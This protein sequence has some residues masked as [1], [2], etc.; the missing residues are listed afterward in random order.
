MT[1]IMYNE[2]LVT[3][4]Y[5]VIAAVGTTYSLDLET[6][7]EVP[8]AL[9]ELTANAEQY[10]QKPHY[11]LEV[12]NQVA[13]KFCVFC[14]A[15][16]IRDNLTQEHLLTL[17]ENS[18]CSIQLPAYGK[19]FASFH[20][21]IWIILEENKQKT[22]LKQAKV[23][24]MSR[25][26]TYSTDIDVV[27]VLTGK[28][29]RR[30]AKRASQVKHQPLIDFLH[31][32]EGNANR[33]A[34][35]KY[36]I[37]TL[38]EALKNVETFDIDGPWFDE[39]DYR[40]LPM[41]INGY[42]GKEIQK[43]MLEKATDTL[44][45][46]PFVD[47]ET[48]T[49]LANV[50]GKHALITQPQSC[51]K[52]V[53][54]LFGEDIYSTKLALT[55]PEDGN[56]IV[57]V[58]EK[59]YF[60]S[61]PSGHYLYLGSTNASQNGFNRNV[62]FMLRLHFR[63]NMASFNRLLPMFVNNDKNC[64][65]ERVTIAYPHDPDAIDEQRKLQLALR[66]AIAAIQKATIEATDNGMYTI[67]VHCKELKSNYKYAI[68]PIY[69][70]TKKQKLSQL[71]NF[72]NISLINL[73]EFYV[74]ECEEKK[75]VIKIKTFGMPSGRAQAIEN[76]ILNTQDKI[77]DY[78]AYMLS[79]DPDGYLEQM[80]LHDQEKKQKSIGGGLAFQG[81]TLYEDLLRMA[82][83]NPERIKRA[84]D[85]LSHCNESTMVDGL[86]K[87]LKDIQGVLPKIKRI[88]EEN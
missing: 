55:A 86:S 21:K 18:V 39:E 88:K 69:E 20:P 29:M 36:L 19:S 84:I 38:S 73:S 48:V 30:A 42:S 63:R 82:Y 76:N 10:V 77:I 51:S 60:I 31:W 11:L 62:E 61:N 14:N 40:F 3:P 50:R 15:G 37:T 59:I 52:E 87:L 26:L 85:T 74:I 35:V 43:E 57:N 54:Q 79:T 25:N 58:H 8:I 5:R 4:G 32:L 68:Y 24:I 64:P 23:M 44:T 13:S 49:A 81:L 1:N 34:N 65:F 41:G 67:T 46:S 2:A 27:C 71:T 12:I 53:I 47:L 9:G 22:D 17:L 75:S 45:I 28:V 6:L 72:E 83:H 78:L 56:N 16:N 7:L 70:E 33:N 80:L 66:Q